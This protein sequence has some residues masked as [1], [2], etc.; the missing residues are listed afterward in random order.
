[1]NL[2]F[3]MIV[4]EAYF[5]VGVLTYVL[6]VYGEPI[7]CTRWKGQTVGGRIRTLLKIGVVWPAFY[8]RY[9]WRG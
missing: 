8:I 9:A 2:V 6:F 3:W 7:R 4:F 5:A 1:M